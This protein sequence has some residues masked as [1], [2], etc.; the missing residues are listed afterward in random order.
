MMASSTGLLRFLPVVVAIG[1]MA[2]GILILAIPAATG[3]A[4]PAWTGLA[5][6][7]AWD[8]ANLVIVPVSLAVIAFLFSDR[9]RLEDREIARAQREQDLRMAEQQRSTDNEIA[10]N[11]EREEALQAYLSTMTELILGHDLA[12][13]KVA[14]IA[15]ARTISLLSRL[16]GN[17]RSAVLEFLVEAGLVAAE[18]PTIRLSGADLSN[19][20]GVRFAMT[21]VSLSGA[22]LS[23]SR[24]AHAS[25]RSSDLR[26]ADLTEVDL[27][28]ADLFNTDLCGANLWRTD[29]SRAILV[30]ANLSKGIPS[31]ASLSPAKAKADAREAE[32]NWLAKL[33]DATFERAKYSY[34]TKWPAGFDPKVRGAFD[35]GG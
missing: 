23:K 3:G 24:L 21:G 20:Q 35:I 8:L 27:S 18:K 5:G 7:T 26:Y 33:A 9:Q 19:M 12:D 1:A 13:A 2:I 11:R 10:L 6:K 31:R 22:N 15:Q 14:A 32:E 16:D 4:W 29:F 25:I 34:M 30:G 17:R 28:D